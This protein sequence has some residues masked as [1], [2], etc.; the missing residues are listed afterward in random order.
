MGTV[1]AKFYVAEK[2]ETA[3]GSRVVILRAVSKHGPSDPAD[4]EQFWKATPN[5]ELTI[6][7]GSGEGDAAFEHFATRLGKNVYLDIVDEQDRYHSCV[8]KWS[9]GVAQ[10]AVDCPE[11]DP[12]QVTVLINGKP[13]IVDRSLPYV[14]LVELAG[15][16]DEASVTVHVPSQER[17]DEPGRWPADRGYEGRTLVR[18]QVLA[19]YEGMVISAVVTGN[20]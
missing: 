7:L 2:R 9:G 11:Y 17:R 8:T 14:T 6:T 13:T 1:T 20:A 15:V 10:H 12:P 4:N 19:T 5:G 16:S 3:Y 18:G